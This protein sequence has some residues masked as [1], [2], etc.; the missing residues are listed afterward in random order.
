MNCKVNLFLNYYCNFRF[1]LLEH[2]YKDFNK[3]FFASLTKRLAEA[4]EQGD[5]LCRHIFRLAG[6][7]LAKHILAVTPQIDPAL[8]SGPFGLPIVCVGSVWK[9]WKYLQPGFQEILGLN[10]N[11]APRLTRFSLL[12][13]KVATAFGAACYSAKNT[14]IP[15]KYDE[16]IQVFYSHG[17]E[18]DIGCLKNGLDIANPITAQ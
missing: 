16:I 14:N 13:L 15:R 6:Q 9:S 3:S 5:P 11:Q 1:E 7:V 8:H 12:R 18:S 17:L 4:A 2:C 10:P